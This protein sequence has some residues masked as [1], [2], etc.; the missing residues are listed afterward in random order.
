MRQVDPALPS[1]RFPKLVA[2]LARR[3]ASLLIQLRTGHVPLNHHLHTIGRADTQRCPGCGAAKE[4]VLHFVLQCPKYALQRRVYFGPLG[5]NGQ[6]RDYL[7]SMKE[8]IERL[9]KFVNATRRLHQTFGDLRTTDQAGRGG[10][11]RNG[12]DGE[13]RGRGR[14]RGDNAPRPLR[15]TTLSFLTSS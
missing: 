12:R 1:S 14:Q 15:Q 13:G 11:T 2:P 7:L 6:R 4:T 3:N 8:G 10:G 5:C 9:F